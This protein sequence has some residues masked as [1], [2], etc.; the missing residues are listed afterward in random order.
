[1]IRLLVEA[2]ALP[3]EA[4]KFSLSRMRR[5][6]KEEKEEEEEKEG[7]QG[8]CSARHGWPGPSGPGVEIPL[9][10]PILASRA[11]TP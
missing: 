5:R 9:V 2:P 11:I 7:S 8:A 1:L 6:R 10:L 3:D 4:L